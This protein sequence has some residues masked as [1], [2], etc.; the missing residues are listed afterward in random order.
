MGGQACCPEQAWRPAES[1]AAAATFSLQKTPCQG[2]P[3]S[4]SVAQQEGV[5]HPLRTGSWRC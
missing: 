2:F 3:C 1:A 5:P 4:V